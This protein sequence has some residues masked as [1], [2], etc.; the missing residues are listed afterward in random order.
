MT[1]VIISNASLKEG[2]LVIFSPYC[3]APLAYR[4]EK[5]NIKTLNSASNPPQQNFTIMMIH[6]LKVLHVVS[7]ILWTGVLLYMPFLLAMQAEANSKT[8]PDRSGAIKQ[9][10]AITKGLWIKTAWP[11]MILVILFGAGLMHPYF[12]SPWFWVKMPLVSVMV[13]HHHAIHFAYNALQNDKYVR[14]PAQLRM[15]SQTS[16]ELLLATVALAIMKDALNNI[17]MIGGISIGLILILLFVRSIMK[18]RSKK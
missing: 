14:T 18:S 13:V 6:I 15:M 11:A 1:R 3:L 4:I 10:K 16:I 7:V 12:S 9:L 2:K 5:F 17:L 8:E